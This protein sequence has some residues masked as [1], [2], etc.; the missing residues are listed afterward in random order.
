MKIKIRTAP[1]GVMRRLSANQLKNV[2]PLALA[3]N[4][5]MTASPA[6]AKSGQIKIASATIVSI[7]Y[8]LSLMR[9]PCR[10]IVPYSRWSVNGY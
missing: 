2:L 10:V 9:V 7:I 1:T 6:A 5:T 8:S 4:P 3:V